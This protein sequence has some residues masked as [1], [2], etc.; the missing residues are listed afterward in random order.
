MALQ[1]HKVKHL[2]DNSNNFLS[3]PELQAKSDLKLV[4]SDTTVSYLDLSFFGKYTKNNFILEDS[5][6]ESF[7]EKIDK[8]DRKSSVVYKNWFPKNLHLLSELNRNGLI[9]AILKIQKT[10]NGMKPIN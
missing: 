7:S 3:F 4:L 1:R 2:K 6:Y 10:L 5:K 9:I 8:S